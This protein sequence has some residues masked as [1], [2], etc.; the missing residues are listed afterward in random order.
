[1]RD[2]TRVE[3]RGVAEGSTEVSEVSWAKTG[4]DKSGGLAD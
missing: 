4:K 2:T 1:M 3:W